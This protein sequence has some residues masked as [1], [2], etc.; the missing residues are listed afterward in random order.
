MALADWVLL[1]LPAGPHVDLTGTVTA[2]AKSQH[3]F[4]SS[5]KHSLELVQQF[6]AGVHACSQR[7]VMNG[8]AFCGCTGLD[9][10][11]Q[12]LSWLLEI[13]AVVDDCLETQLAN[14]LH[15]LGAN[16]ATHRHVIR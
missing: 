11:M 14:L 2:S 6:L 4:F 12:G 5:I 8:K 9:F 7:Q 3:R 13:G 1:R 10:S 16:L 15:V